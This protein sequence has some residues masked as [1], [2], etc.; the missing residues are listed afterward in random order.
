MCIDDQER[1]D[2][3]ICEYQVFVTVIRK[4][5]V[6]VAKYSIKTNFV[7]TSLPFYENCF[8]QRLPVLFSETNHEH[9]TVCYQTQSSA[10]LKSDH[11]HS[12][13]TSFQC[14]QSLEFR[15]VE[16]L[17]ECHSLLI[18]LTTLNSISGTAVPLYQPEQ[19]L[20]NL[21]LS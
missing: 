18:V 21:L 15:R 8:A 17:H 7:D 3:F 5:E 19:Q 9:L 4:K 2:S 13:N 1:I 20:N 6:S 10:G 12:I 14:H 16:A 11:T